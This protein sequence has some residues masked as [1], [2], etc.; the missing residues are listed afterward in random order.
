MIWWAEGR[1]FISLNSADIDWGR[2]N[3]W[4]IYQVSARIRQYVTATENSINHREN[5]MI[6][7]RATNCPLKFHRATMK[8]VTDLS[9]L[10]L[11]CLG[12]FE[13]QMIEEWCHY[14]LLLGRRYGC[15]MSIAS[16]SQER[17]GLVKEILEVA[18]KPVQHQHF[19]LYCCTRQRSAGAHLA[20]R[21]EAC[22][23]L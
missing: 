4:S 5:F 3:D 2:E 21:V 6:K 10:S 7:V 23:F 13:N 19:L 12:S 18:N 14:P 9:H 16:Q 15:C 11:L 8:R 20:S 17:V 22:H 1:S